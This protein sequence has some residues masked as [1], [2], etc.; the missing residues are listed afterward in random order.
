M[1]KRG[2]WENKGEAVGPRPL[3][4]LVPESEN[5]QKADMADPRTRL[6]HWLTS[7]SHPLTAR[8]LVNRIWQN[9]F[10]AGI[11]KTVNDFGLKGARPSHP[12]LLDWLA[13]TLVADGWRLKDLHR[14][15]VLSATYRQSNR[16][17]AEAVA[18]ISDPE[19]RLL[20]KF[21]RR[22]LSAEEIRDAM[23]AVSGRMN[24]K[25]GGLSVMIPV[26]AVLVRQ[27][28]KPSQWN[29]GH[30]PSE[31]DRR[32][33]YLLAKRN[34]RLP[35]LDTF[36]APATLTSCGRRESSTHAP[37]ALELLNGRLSNDL[38]TS[39]A[40]R[41]RATC[42]ANA[43]MI[44]ECGFHEALGRSPTAEERSLS[45]AF[46]RDQPLHEYALT[47]FNLNG[48]LYAP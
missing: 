40:E 8:V 37:Q 42:G 13:G 15:I 44:M 31:H 33:I 34:L 12:E 14:T 39:F 43:E 20:W 6:A 38:A 23:L 16:S 47:L 7:P 29:V 27:L 17:P 46:L 21:N 4:V 30:D 25:E 32:S 24:L 26:D 1:L 22:R 18:G 28:Y 48:F 11:V 45:L 5:E 2:V 10:G 9:H 36:D 41:L 35:F 19:N 3:S